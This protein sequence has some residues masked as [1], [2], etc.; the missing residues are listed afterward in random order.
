MEKQPVYEE[1]KTGAPITVAVTQAVVETRLLP[2]PGEGISRVLSITTEPTINSA[3]TFNGEARFGGRVDFKVLYLTGDGTNRCLGCSAEFSDKTESDKLKPDTVIWVKASVIDTD[4]VSLKPDEIKLAA[5]VEIKI[6]AIAEENINYLASGGDGVYTQEEKIE[7]SRFIASGKSVF[8]GTGAVENTRLCRVLLAEHRAIILSASSERDVVTVGGVIVSDICGET[9][10][11]LIASVRIE[12][13]FTEEISAPEVR[14]GDVVA[15]ESS[16]SGEVQLIEGEKGNTIS[17][18]YALET[19]FTAFATESKTIVTDAFLPTH[20]L[21]CERNQTK[22]V[23]ISE[24][25]CHT[26]KI[27]G[28]V[29]LA[30]NAE[31][32]DNILALTGFSVAV[33]S[34][35]SYDGEALVEGLI[36]GNIIYYGAQENSKCSTV[37]EI[38]FSLKIPVYGLTASD[39]ITANGFVNAAAAKIRRANEIDVKADIVFT[40]RKEMEREIGFIRTLTVGEARTLP[41][42]AISVYVVSS[43]ES[44]WD[45]AKALGTTPEIIVSQNDGLELPLKGGEKIMLFRHLDRN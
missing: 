24:N 44:L 23:T 40:I 26:E 32:V 1:I 39:R 25:I 12:T 28:S 15:T 35:L 14:A 6:F 9:D 16:V 4:V 10:D 21:I 29:T 11:E 7:Y 42:S 30:Q 20:E 17:V 27:E 45:V 18:E 41:T 5:V 38:P 19:K 34:A 36:S 33:T 2:Q 31:N 43:K 8:S 3:E 22:A 13:P 37:V